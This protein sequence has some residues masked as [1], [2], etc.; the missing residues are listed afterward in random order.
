MNKKIKIAS[1][2]ISASLLVSP[3]SVLINHYDNVAKANNY[4]NLNI[5]KMLYLNKNEQYVVVNKNDYFITEYVVDNK[6]IYSVILKGKEHLSKDEKEKYLNLAKKDIEKLPQ[7]RAFPLL[8]VIT[9]VAGL[10]TVVGISND[11]YKTYYKPDIDEVSRAES[12][13]NGWISISKDYKTMWFYKENGNFKSGWHWDDYY[14]GWY[15]FYDIKFSFFLRSD[16]YASLMYNPRFENSPWLKIND[17]WYEFE[18]GGKLIQYS[19]WREYNGKWLYHL[20]GDYGAVAGQGLYIA[21]TW[22]DFD[23]NGYWV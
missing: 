13:Q 20:P 11:I 22:Y 4:S 5:G 7:D 19:G 6:K 9:I 14:D 2:V 17:K 15:F 12:V 1:A 10:A 18:D 8:V 3:I 21:G 16:V 23:E